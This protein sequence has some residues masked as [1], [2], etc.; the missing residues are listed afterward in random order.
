MLKAVAKPLKRAQVT[1]YHRAGQTATFL[2]TRQ[3]RNL[4]FVGSTTPQAT[5][6]I[7]NSLKTHVIRP[8]GNSRQPA[9]EATG[10]YHVCSYRRL[11]NRLS[12][13]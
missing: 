10:H 6:A 11:L 12:K 13:V 1:T 3:L 7:R 4:Q 5:A 8:G 9:T 2:E